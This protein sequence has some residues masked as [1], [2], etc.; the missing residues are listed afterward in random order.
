[1]SDYDDDDDQRLNSLPA[2]VIKDRLTELGVGFGDCTTKDDLVHR[3]ERTIAS[4]T[5]KSRA[6]FWHG[7]NGAPSAAK[8]P[9]QSDTQARAQQSQEEQQQQQRKKDEALA[10]KLQQEEED[11][12]K[13]SNQQETNRSSEA[14]Q[15]GGAETATKEQKQG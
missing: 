4:G 12:A 8:L 15:E 3:L 14:S 10:R 6:S 7:D 11:R 1:M 5:A 9:S 2:K 13:T